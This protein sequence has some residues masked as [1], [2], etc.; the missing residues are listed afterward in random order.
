MFNQ[1][2]YFRFDVNL[3]QWTLQR[4]TSIQPYVPKDLTIKPSIGRLKSTWQGT[5]TNKRR[6]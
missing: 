3:R 4:E 5:K 2:K 1:W 6:K